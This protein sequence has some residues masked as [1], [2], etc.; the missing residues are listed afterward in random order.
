MK[1]SILPIFIILLLSLALPFSSSF[2][3][4]NQFSGTLPNVQTSTHSF[5]ETTELAEKLWA[6]QTSRFIQLYEQGQYN[7]AQKMALRT[8]EFADNYFGIND[9][10]ASEYWHIEVVK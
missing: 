6:E 3:S 2:A 9:G 10:L 5:H 4:S 1:N 7:E 8:Y